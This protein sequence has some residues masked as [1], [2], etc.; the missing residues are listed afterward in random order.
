M[1]TKSLVLFIGIITV[2]SC[3]KSNADLK[4]T[5]ADPVVQKGVEYLVTQISKDEFSDLNFDKIQIIKDSNDHTGSFVVQSKTL[6]NASAVL[7]K[8]AEGFTGNWLK[9]EDSQESGTIKT[10]SFNQKIKSEVTFVEGRPTKIIK[11]ENGIE[12]KTLIKYQSGN[13]IVS[14]K[15][16]V[17]QVVNGVQTSETGNVGGGGSVT[18]QPVVVTAY[19]TSMGTSALLYSLYWA[20]M[21]NAIYNF[22]YTPNNPSMGGGTANPTRISFFQGPSKL[23]NIANY[24]KC[25]TNIPGTTNTYKITIAVDQPI[26]GSRSAWS[27]NPVGAAT[28]AGSGGVPANVGHTFI[29]L[30]QTT[31]SGAVTQRTVGFYPS[32]NVNPASPISGGELHN[33]EAYRDFDVSLSV[34][35]TSSQFFNAINY[36]NSTYSTGSVNYDL[37]M[38]N[39]TTFGIA[40]M[41]QAGVN[42]NATIGSW[43]G[44]SGYNPGDLGEDIRAMTLQPNMTMSPYHFSH[45]NRGECY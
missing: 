26:K 37:N 27:F 21:Q 39:C 10:W 12:K 23:T 17:T 29:I 15:V 30:T 25:F 38:M 22:Q 36:I 13:S 34:T 11:N 20:T 31:S 19:V 7:I 28:S 24:L 3:V 33:N 32:G 42:M 16:T 41:A 6:G 18:L 43:A 40:V 8:N 9:Y 14:G 5:F 4:L 45:T 35:M 2:Y 1:N 44:G